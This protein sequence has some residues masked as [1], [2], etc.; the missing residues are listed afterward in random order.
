M[1]MVLAI[2]LL[3][4]LGGDDLTGR[5]WSAGLAA[6]ALL[7]VGVC[8]FSIQRSVLGPLQHARLACQTMAGGDMT[9]HVHADRKDEMGQLLRSMRQ[10]AINLKSVIGDVRNNLEEIG[11]ATGEIAAGN[12]NL[13]ARTEAQTSA[14]EQTASSMEELAAIGRQNSEN[15]VHASK[16]AGEAMRIASDGGQAV[17]DVVHTM[18]EIGNASN[19]MTNIIGMI[20]AIAFQTNILAL[21][22]AVEAARAGE[23][24]R[25]FAVVAAEVRSLAQRSAAAAKEIKEMLAVSADKVNAGVTL[26]ERAGSTM[27]ETIASVRHVTGIMNEIAS[28]S[29]EQSAG[30]AQV[31]TAVVQ[32]D[33]VTQQNAALVEEAAAAAVS[34]EGQTINVVQ[35]LQVFKLA[36]TSQR[37]SPSGGKSTTRG[38]AS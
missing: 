20:E 34:L 15:A 5:W 29:A 31:N 4:Y 23:Q 9:F 25:G 30:I 11:T 21:N 2:V 35:A 19:K 22:A 14:L 33:D 27:A 10:L 38:F 7:S 8:W 37:R 18:S 28:A 17:N 26:A 1:L 32:M 3:P 6:A 12:M 36:A 16:L 13:S 24:G